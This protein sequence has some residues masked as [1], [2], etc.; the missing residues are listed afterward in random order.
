MRAGTIENRLIHVSW[1]TKDQL[2]KIRITQCIYI[3]PPQWLHL[4]PHAL[5]Q[6]F[7]LIWHTVTDTRIT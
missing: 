5:T 6:Q 3:V 4:T 7:I 2:Q 1:S